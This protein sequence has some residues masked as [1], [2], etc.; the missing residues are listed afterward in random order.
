MSAK[1][2]IVSFTVTIRSGY[3]AQGRPMPATVS[4][5]GEEVQI[6]CGLLGGY[7]GPLA[8]LEAALEYLK[9]A[10]DREAAA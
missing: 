1:G 2:P 7:R 9:D 4:L 3:R 8:D 5:T 6:R 10:R